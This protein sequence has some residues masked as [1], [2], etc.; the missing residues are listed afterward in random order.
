MYPN[1]EIPAWI[2]SNYFYKEMTPILRWC[3]LPFLLLFSVS[4]VVFVGRGLEKIGILRTK[5]FQ[6][7]LG[8]RFG[9]KGR[10]VD[11]V[12]WVNG[13]VISFL[14]VMAIPAYLLSR[15][16]MRRCGGMASN[17]PRA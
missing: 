1:E 7:K 3:L 2:W 16:S 5:I 8:E 11:W 6:C 9:L 13:V 12:L 14:L 4:V 15:D 10:L 17:S